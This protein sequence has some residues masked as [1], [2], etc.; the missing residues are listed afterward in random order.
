MSLKCVRDCLTQIF[1]LNVAN[2]GCPYIQ[3][4]SS[5]D[6]Y[7]LQGVSLTSGFLISVAQISFLWSK[8]N[9]RFFLRVT[10]WSH[11]DAT[12]INEWW[13]TC[14]AALRTH[15]LFWYVLCVTLAWLFERL[16]ES[17]WTSGVVNRRISFRLIASEILIFDLS[18]LNRFLSVQSTIVLLLILEVRIVI[19]CSFVIL[20][21]HFIVI[22]VKARK[23]VRW[24]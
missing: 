11:A 18:R 12:L 17:V 4:A 2:W 21:S 19:V 3:V 9:E 15:Y 20:P 7:S 1:S 24:V 10:W 22:V 6:L 16:T 13:V 5:R 23:W 14:P 8:R